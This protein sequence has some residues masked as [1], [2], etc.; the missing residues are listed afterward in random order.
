MTRKK[1]FRTV[2]N[3]TRYALENPE[4]HALTH[5]ADPD[6]AVVHQE[7]RGQRELAG[8]DVLP[9]RGSENPAWVKMGVVFGAKVPG[10]DLF[11]RV[12]LPA[13]WKKVPTDHHLY[14]HLVDDRGRPRAQ[15][16]YKA[17]SYDRD[18][19]VHV[20]RVT[21]DDVYGHDTE[22]CDT[23]GCSGLERYY[24]ELRADGVKRGDIVVKPKTCVKCGQPIPE[25]MLDGFED[26]RC[27]GCAD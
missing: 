18:A 1:N 3:T 15:I 20:T 9:S 17:A 13:G 22:H 5:M 14:S 8:A 25:P 2:T 6:C 11:R 7:A 24:P 10:D 12:E 27:K 23:S 4:L 19:S 26:E 21:G 16:M